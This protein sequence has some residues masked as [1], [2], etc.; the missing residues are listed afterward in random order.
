MRLVICMFVLANMYNFSIVAMQQ[1]SA[2][3]RYMNAVQ[4]NSKQYEHHNRH[5]SNKGEIYECLDSNSL[6][7]NLDVQDL[8]IS[9]EKIKQQ[10]EY[11]SHSMQK[12][13]LQSYLQTVQNGSEQ[14]K[15]Q[16]NADSSENN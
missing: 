3:Q 2:W 12:S 8:Q 10:Q 5:K 1:Q 11:G 4:D 15:N 14:Y 16:N 7:L 13:T 6:F 9:W